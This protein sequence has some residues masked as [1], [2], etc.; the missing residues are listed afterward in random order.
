MP[1]FGYCCRKCTWSG[2]ILIR[3]AEAPV[4][5][6]CGSQALEKQMSHFAPMRGAEKSTAHAPACASCCNASGS[7]PYQG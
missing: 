4:C 5:P 7:C 6:E 1:V 3:G 2:E